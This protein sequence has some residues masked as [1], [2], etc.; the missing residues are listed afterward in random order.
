MTTQDPDLE[1][2]QQHPNNGGA[3]DLD[4]ATE[5]IDFPDLSGWELTEVQHGDYWLATGDCP[6]CGHPMYVTL[7]RSYYRSQAQRE[8]VARLPVECQCEFV[9]TDGKRGCGR[10]WTVEV[11]E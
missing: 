6:G 7:R 5:A 3:V 1:Q 2:A 4:W 10:Y 9:H 11:Y 8:P